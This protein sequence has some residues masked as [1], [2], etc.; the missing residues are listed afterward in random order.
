VPDI[1]YDVDEYVAT[2]TLNRPER[3]NAFTTAMVDAWAD[4]LI[5]AVDGAPV[6]AGTDM[7]LMCDCRVGS[8]TARLAEAYDAFVSHRSPKFT[9]K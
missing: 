6:G 3:K 1:E 5:A 8:R 4:A 9:G 2:I 7:A